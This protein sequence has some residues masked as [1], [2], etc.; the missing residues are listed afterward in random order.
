VKPSG[1]LLTCDHFAGEGGMSN[2]ELFM[3][4]D[5]HHSAM[6]EGGFSTVELLMLKGG[7]VLFAAHGGD[8][9]ASE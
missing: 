8:G 7:L 6:R 2:N 9:G 3:T 4:P 5:E 1:I